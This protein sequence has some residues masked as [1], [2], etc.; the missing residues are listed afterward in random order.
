M[1]VIESKIIIKNHIQQPST[2]TKND[3]QTLYKVSP[4]VQAINLIITS[5]AINV[6][7]SGQLHIT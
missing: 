2:N 1:D 6:D 3:F 4:G 7:V 5:V